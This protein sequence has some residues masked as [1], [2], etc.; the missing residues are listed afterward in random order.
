MLVSTGRAQEAFPGAAQCTG[1][2]Q[3][4]Q[5][6]QAG[7]P[8]SSFASRPSKLQRAGNTS[9]QLMWLKPFEHLSLTCMSLVLPLCMVSQLVKLS[10][11]YFRYCC[12]VQLSAGSPFPFDTQPSPA[13]LW[14]LCGG[15][16]LLSSL[17]QLLR[18]A[19][20]PLGGCASAAEAGALL[21]GCHGRRE[22]APF[23]LQLSGPSLAD[24]S[25]TAA[26]QASCIPCLAL[27]GLIFPSHCQASPGA[28]FLSSLLQYA[29]SQGVA[30]W[31]LT[32]LCLC[33]V[34]IFHD[35]GPSVCR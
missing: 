35:Q 2:F 6:E 15:S 8:C 33:F 18:S 3:A 31:L 23:V 5:S 20:M 32:F 22:D 14:G 21:L 11:G 19:F 4:A 16:P 10:P 13:W 27:Q 28:E 26:L 24:F 29:V 17:S 1:G 34:Y 25:L 7:N 12:A 30:A 9:V